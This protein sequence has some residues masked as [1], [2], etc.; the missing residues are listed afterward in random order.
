MGLMIIFKPILPLLLILTFIPCLLTF[1]FTNLPNIWKYD[2]IKKLKL[3][4]GKEQGNIKD[5][6]IPSSYSGISLV[7][8]LASAQEAGLKNT[9]KLKSLVAKSFVE[10][11][12]LAKEQ[13]KPL[14]T[15]LT[16]I[17]YIDED[18]TEAIN[19]SRI[20]QNQLSSIDRTPSSIM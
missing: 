1:K 20:I 17:D 13:L 4:D 18:D 15:A 2:T 7:E 11:Y 19:L 5:S 14:T 3:L 8:L 12:E 9:S 6:T 16:Y 10:R